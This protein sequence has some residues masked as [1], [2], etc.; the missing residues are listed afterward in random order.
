MFLCFNVYVYID[1]EL[2]FLK[3]FAGIFYMYNKNFQQVLFK[4]IYYNYEKKAK[5]N[6]NGNWVTE[7]DRPRLISGESASLTYESREI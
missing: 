6:Q 2:R 1:I 5:E 4:K 3:K 7:R